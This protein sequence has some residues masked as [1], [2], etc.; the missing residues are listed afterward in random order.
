MWLIMNLKG[1]RNLKMPSDI[2]VFPPNY[3]FIWEKLQDIPLLQWALP[4]KTN[5]APWVDWRLQDSTRLFQV[6]TNILYHH[7]MASVSWLCKQRSCGVYVS[8]MQVVE[9]ITTW[10]AFP[11]TISCKG[12]HMESHDWWAPI[13]FG[14][15]VSFAPFNWRIVHIGSLNV[16]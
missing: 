1:C 6:P 12:I 5:V 14:T 13:R 10:L 8:Q 3:G 9:D 11:S 15:L 7:A 16:L 4:L 2:Y